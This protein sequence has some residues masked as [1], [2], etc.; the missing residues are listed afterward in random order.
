MSYLRKVLQPGEKILK[1]GKLHWIIYRD[2]IIAFI[3]SL[4]IILL[5]SLDL[6]N[7]VKTV[8]AVAG[9]VFVGVAVCLAV[10]AWL[11]QWISEIAVT[12]QRIIY[13]HGLIRRHTSEMNMDKVESV[14]VTQSIIGR[15][16]DFG[17]IHIRG[18]GEGIEHLHKISKPIDLRNCITSR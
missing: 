18:T 9:F 17:S 4:A 8:I 15:V 2:A 7:L 5:A 14:T 16:L 13:K 1:I 12:N 3:L 10:A 6:S 11:D